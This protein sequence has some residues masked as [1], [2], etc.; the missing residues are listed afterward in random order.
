MN[1]FVESFQASTETSGLTLSIVT[2]LLTV[3]T[4]PALSF[5]V[6]M[7]ANVPPSSGISPLEIDQPLDE[8]ST[9][10]SPPLRV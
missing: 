10:A 6:M 5:A 7:Y 3:A 2:V 9:F 1:V 4:E 8:S